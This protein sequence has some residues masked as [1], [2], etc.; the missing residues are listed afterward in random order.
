MLNGIKSPFIT[1]TATNGSKL[2]LHFDT[3]ANGITLSDNVKKKLEQKVSSEKT[4]TSFGANKNRKGKEG[5][6]KD[7]SFFIGNYIFNLSEIGVSNIEINPG[8]LIHLNGRI[9][10]SPFLNGIISFDYQNGIFE[11]SESK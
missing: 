9:G 8:N 10:N 1:A 3:G 5:I 4:V 6:I 7:F 11:Y 2:F